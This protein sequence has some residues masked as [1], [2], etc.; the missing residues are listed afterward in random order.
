[1]IPS[2]RV[3]YDRSSGRLL[4]LRDEQGVRCRHTV[5]TGRINVGPFPRHFMPGY[6]HVV[7]S[8][9]FKAALLRVDARGQVPEHLWRYSNGYQ[10]TNHCFA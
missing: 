8:G 10:R 2:R 4:V 6:H 9:Q 5:P 1:M 3:R 7:P